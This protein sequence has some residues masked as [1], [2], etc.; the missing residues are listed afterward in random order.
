MTKIAG[1]QDLSFENL[2]KVSYIF[3]PKTVYP[4]G[5]YV[6]IRTVMYNCRLLSVF[7][8]IAFILS[9]LASQNQKNGERVVRIGIFPFEPINFIN[10][11]GQA[12]GFHPDLIQ[13]I[14]GQSG[15]KVRYVEGSW[16]QGL[17]RLQ[18]GEIDLMMSVARSA[19]REKSM[20]FGKEATMELWGQVFIPPGST[21]RNINDLRDKTVGV[22]KNDISGINL[23]RTADSFGIS[24]RIKEYATH[25][26]VFTAVE[27]G[28]VDAGA[29]PQH[30]GLRNREDY[31][32][33]ES[34]IL[35]SP[36]SIYFT[37]KKGE[38]TG[39][40]ED[41]DR[42]LKEWKSDKD[43]IYFKAINRWLVGKE[44]RQEMVPF[45]ARI[46]LFLA[47]FLGI[48]TVGSLLLMRQLIQSKAA[49]IRAGE[50]R[51]RNLFDQIEN[52]III[53]DG[54][55]TIL[56]VNPFALSFLEKSW[57]ELTGRNIRGLGILP[58]EI[59]DQYKRDT[60]QF[61]DVIAEI[62]PAGRKEFVRWTIKGIK[63]NPADS[64][65]LLCSG[66][67]ITAMMESESA[68]KESQEQFTSF[69]NNLPAYAYLKNTRGDFLYYNTAIKALLHTDY[70]LPAPRD[71]LKNK[72]AREQVKMAEAR[73]LSGES[74]IE[75][76][77]YE[78]VLGDES[79]QQ[80]LRET[81][82]AVHL[83]TGELRLGGIGFDVSETFAIE[84]QLNQARKMQAIGELAG[85]IAHDFNNQLSGI[86]G[87]A[88]LLIRGIDDPQKERYSRK[89]VEG[90]ERASE[91][92]K[93]LLNFSRKG[94][95]ES[96]SLHLNEVIIDM[97]NLLSHSM[98]KTVRI[99]F[100]QKTDNDLIQG[101]PNQIQNALL[102][103]AINARDAMRGEGDLY[104]TTQKITANDKM[105]ALQ[106][107]AI[108][109]GH[110]LKVSVEDTGSGMNRETQNK[111][112]E[113]FFTTK[114]EGKGTGMGLA[115]VYST[116]KDHDGSVTVQ[117]TPGKGTVFS[118][119]FPCSGDETA[120][121]PYREKGGEYVETTGPYDIAIIDDEAMIRDF[122]SLSLRD[123][124]HRVAL[125][126]GGKQAITAFKN[127]NVSFDLVILDMIM[128]GMDGPE[129]YRELMKIRP[130]LPVLL[131]SGYSRKE[132]LLELIKKPRILYLQK[133]YSITDLYEAIEKLMAECSGVK[134][135]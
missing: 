124:G 125:F 72:E 45:W 37:V 27:R 8:F 51:Y 89:L 121:V 69:M 59:I 32:L 3:L 53:L 61:D 24:F 79:L 101:D 63:D 48:L 122:L 95:K 21:I 41:V 29:A 4:D 30:F 109:T 135:I 44:L 18:S 93:Q 60:L 57:D 13:E 23:I 39:L 55:G 117:S 116:L 103:I 82:F 54:E 34:L 108:K 40:L 11:S 17:E 77:E 114:K 28:E 62:Q 71:I 111:I 64:G 42:L 107:Y 26:D 22:M 68:L 134:K 127:S 66:V 98:E 56:Q 85:G 99:H 38:N 83:P 20:D 84:E 14:A 128:P 97:I 112:F 88:D 87:Y 118:L 31:E 119:Y 94:T 113:P 110:Y 78:A 7:I 132:D 2:N 105:V 47:I 120:A 102:N 50:R 75:T 70:E 74:E 123:K 16:S 76:I 73:I 115:M 67:Q 49:E 33:A 86:M 12:A 35:Y 65:A 91:T 106:G 90:I 58:S 96:R 92:T 10:D 25:H 15:W 36:F 19:E 131:S 104:F 5:L 126:E 129:T 46:V 81:I 1:D 130:E 43:S 52:I 80:R 100:D 9:P 133:P 6:I